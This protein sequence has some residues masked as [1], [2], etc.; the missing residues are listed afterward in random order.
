MVGSIV[1]AQKIKRSGWIYFLSKSFLEVGE[2]IKSL[3][4]CVRG[5]ETL[6]G[7]SKTAEISAAGYGLLQVEQ[8]DEATAKC[9]LENT[10]R[11]A[12]GDRSKGK[13]KRGVTPCI[14]YVISL[15]SFLLNSIV[16]RSQRIH[17]VGGCISPYL[18]CSWSS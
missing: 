10:F 17:D 8:G 6:P 15:E 2:D 16:L 14:G 4:R 1:T 11:G 13:L 9:R 5:Y 12:G 18:E 7:S 3:G